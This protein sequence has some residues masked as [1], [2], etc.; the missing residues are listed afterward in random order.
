MASSAAQPRP[1]EASAPFWCAERER[2]WTHTRPSATLE[3]GGNPGSVLMTL[4]R[5]VFLTCVLTAACGGSDE[6]GLFKGGKGGSSSG[7]ASGD[8]G[9]S[10]GGISSGGAP[11]TGGSGGSSAGAG[12]GGSSAG[13]GSS[14][15]GGASGDGGSSAAGGGAGDGGS[16]AVPTGGTGGSGAAPGGTG[17][18]PT[19]G[20]GGTGG[21]VTVGWCKGKCGSSTA[22]PPDNCY[23]DEQCT[24]SNDC[25]PDYGPAC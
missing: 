11:L 15:S 21:V 12:K 24:Q 20:S 2:A 10:S 18:G 7:G 1:Q 3:G 4:R 22:V 23:C 9:S 14:A 5:V 8:G 16:G 25:C 13:G 19:G 6:G 17:G